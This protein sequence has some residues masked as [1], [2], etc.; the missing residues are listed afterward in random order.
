MILRRLVRLL[1]FGCRECRSGTRR[2]FGMALGSTSAFTCS[3]A[4]LPGLMRTLSA[5][6]APPHAAN[7]NNKLA[8]TVIGVP[9][10]TTCVAV[11]IPL[12]FRRFRAENVTRQIP[13]FAS[14][15]QKKASLLAAQHR[16]PAKKEALSAVSFQRIC[17]DPAAGQACRASAPATFASL[18]GLRTI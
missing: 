5:S 9:L 2:Q 16:R 10:S 11:Y 12:P 13:Y 1:R 17:N 6:R 7:R 14:F 3:F 15:S 4:S 18:S 8:I